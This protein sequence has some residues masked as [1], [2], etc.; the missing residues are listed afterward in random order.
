MEGASLKTETKAF[1]LKDGKIFWD[2]KVLS[3]A[4]TIAAEIKTLTFSEKDGSPMGSS[5]FRENGDARF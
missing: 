4:G 1:P 3:D 2:Q 5:S